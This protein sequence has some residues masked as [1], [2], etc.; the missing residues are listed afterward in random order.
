MVVVDQDDHIRIHPGEP[1]LRRAVTVE[2]RLPVGFF[3]PAQVQG[4]PDGRYM[5]RA[6]SG[7][8]LRHY[9]C[10][11]LL[12]LPSMGR[13]PPAIMARY[14][15]WVSPDMA[16]AMYWNDLPSVAPSLEV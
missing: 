11:D 15:S 3:G 10:S 16:P 6:E 14:S 5:R 12:R 8:D 2:Q 13:P 9:C 4:G 1:L 7:N